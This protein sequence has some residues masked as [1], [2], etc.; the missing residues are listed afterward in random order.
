MT[1]SRWRR[2]GQ[3]SAQVASG[4]IRRALGEGVARGGAERLDHPRFTEWLSLDQVGRGLVGTTAV[5]QEPSGCSGVHRCPLGR[6]DPREHCVSHDRVHEAQRPLLGEQPD[7]SERIGSAH[8][9][10]AF[11]PRKRGSGAKLRARPENRRHP[12]ERDAVGP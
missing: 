12:G 10:L 4:D 8:R 7:P 2:L 1:V 6:R 3:R 5:C 9:S 11:K